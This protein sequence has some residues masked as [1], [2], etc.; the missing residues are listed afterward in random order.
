MRDGGT[1]VRRVR[2]YDVITPQALGL[3]APL[4]VLIGLMLFSA[5]QGRTGAVMQLQ[6]WVSGFT[7]LNLLLDFSNLV[8]LGM[9]LWIV[10]RVSDPALPARFRPLSRPGALLGVAAG[11]APSSS[12][13]RSNISAITICTPI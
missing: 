8:I 12:P 9:A 4:L 13:R 10:S 7:G 1:P 5:G 2:W 3:G 6:G 11:W